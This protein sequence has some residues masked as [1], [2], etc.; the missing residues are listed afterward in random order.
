[1]KNNTLIIII[2]L[3]LAIAVALFITVFRFK[4]TPGSSEYA[5]HVPTAATQAAPEHDCAK[6]YSDAEKYFLA[7]ISRESSVSEGEERGIGPEVF[8]RNL[9]ILLENCPDQNVNISGKG[10]L[11]S[12]AG[13]VALYMLAE[14]NSVEPD[15][16]PQA[17]EYMRILRSKY[18]NELIVVPDAAE[19][20]NETGRVVDV[21]RKRMLE[22]FGRS[23]GW[24]DYQAQ[25]INEFGDDDIN[26]S[27]DG[28]CE[29]YYYGK[30][31]EYYESMGNRF[32]FVHE[33]WTGQP[34]EGI[35][36]ERMKMLEKF[37]KEDLSRITQPD[38]CASLYYMMARLYSVLSVSDKDANEKAKY[39]YAIILKNYSD[40]KYASEKGLRLTAYWL[41]GNLRRLNDFFQPVLPIVNRVFY[42]IVIFR[43]P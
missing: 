27:E 20:N 18:K 6:L 13:I 3:S 21:T 40:V 17:V 15:S 31:D 24:Y 1:M 25:D 10:G 35:T 30:L 28:D 19:E 2:L 23:N 43:V 12:K 11:Y 41:K 34:P 38:F 14:A 26:C 42:K 4:K 22:Y 9:K 16:L 5:K 36:M 29:K 8:N 32:G 33:Y 37:L 39:Y 7:N